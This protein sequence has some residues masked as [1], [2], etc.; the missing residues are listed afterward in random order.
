[1]AGQRVQLDSTQHRRGTKDRLSQGFFSPCFDGVVS[2]CKECIPTPSTHLAPRPSH[3]PVVIDIVWLTPSRLLTTI[4]S[5]LDKNK[6][7]TIVGARAFGLST[8]LHLARSGT[9]LNQLNI[10]DR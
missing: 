5:A 6:T 7:F 8:A 1:M 10:Q 3:K 2:T 9:S 4:I